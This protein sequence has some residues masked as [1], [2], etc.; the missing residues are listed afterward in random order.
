MMQLSYCKNLFTNAR[1]NTERLKFGDLN[2]YPNI[3]HVDVDARGIAKVQFQIVLKM[4]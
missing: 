4:A 2:I 1:K 3:L